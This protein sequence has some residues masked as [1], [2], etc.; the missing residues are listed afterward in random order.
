MSASAD[1]LKNRRNNHRGN[2]EMNRKIRVSTAAK[3]M[4]Q[5]GF[6]LLEV[7]IAI[8]IVAMLAAFI[9][10]GLL[11]NKEDAKYSTALTQLE[12]DFP[13]AITRQVSRTQTCS[14]TTIT[15]ALLIERGLPDTTVWNTAWSVGAVTSNLVT[16]N[17]TIDSTDAKTAADM[18][19]ALAKTNNV[20]SATATGNSQIAVSYRCN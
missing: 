13:S 4:K 1:L 11:Q 12:K 20:Q 8:A 6:T 5:Q 2:S 15:K 16:I 3:R 14:A 17:Y 7:V 10:P 18:A 9:L 19:T